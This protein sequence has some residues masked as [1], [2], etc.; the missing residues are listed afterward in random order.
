MP[1]ASLSY[2]LSRSFGVL[3]DLRLKRIWEG[4]VVRLSNSRKCNPV[5]W[6]DSCVLWFC[7]GLFRLIRNGFL[8]RRGFLLFFDYVPPLFH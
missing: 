5:C 6:V 4:E 1:I 3:V 8:F 2:I 7:R